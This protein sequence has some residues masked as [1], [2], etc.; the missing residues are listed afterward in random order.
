MREKLEDTGDGFYRLKNASGAEVRFVITG[1][2]SCIYKRGGKVRKVHNLIML[3]DIEAAERI[4]KRLEGIGNIHSDGRPILGLDSRDLLEITLEEC[5]RVLF[6]PAHIWTPHFSLFGANS[7]FDSIYECFDDLTSHI[8]ALETG[9]SSD[10]PMN[11]RLS[12]LDQFTLISN[13]DAHS[14][15]NLGREANL[16]ETEF[17]YQGIYD[18]LKGGQGFKGTIEFFPEEGKYHFDGHRNCHIR[19]SP[20]QTKAAGG[21]CP[22]CGRKVTVG[23]LHRVEELAD[24]NEGERPLEVKAFHSLV[25]LNE[26]LANA[27]GVGPKTKTVGREYFKLIGKFG[28][29]MS[30]LQE[31]PIEDI[32][33]PV[34]AEA[35]RRLR[36]GRINIEPGFDGEYG[37]IKLVNEEER[38]S[39]M[40]QMSMGSP[41]IIHHEPIEIKSMY[42]QG[43]KES[44]ATLD[45]DHSFS[46]NDQQ[47]NAVI[48]DGG[49]ILVIAGPGTGKTR[50]LIHRVLHL[51]E[52]KGV[53]HDLITGVTF[54]NRAALEMKARLQD[55]LGP[56]VGIQ[57]GTFHGI[58]LNILKE[59][60]GNDFIIIDEEDGVELLR[61]ILGERKDGISASRAVR[62]I[63]LLKSQVIL[64]GDERI[65]PDIE[66]I[67]RAYQEE[68]SYFKALDYDDIL[69]VTLQ[70]FEGDKVSGKIR[71]RFTH[72]L[73]DEFQD[74]NPLQYR[75]VRAFAQDGKNLFV[76]GDPDQAIYGFRGADHRFFQRLYG[77]F[78]K[79]K[80][81]NLSVNYRSTPQILG[82]A[83]V[84]IEQASQGFH[85][86]ALKP[87]RSSGS[88][89]RHIQLPTEL[90]EGIF[91]AHEIGRRVGGMDMLKARGREHIRSFSDIAV[92]FRTG[93]QIIQV[94][95]CLNKEGIPYR[96]VGRERVLN[97]KNIRHLLA[98]L[99]S[100]MDP[101]DDFHH[102]LALKTSPGVEESTVTLVKDLARSEKLSMRQAITVHIPRLARNLEECSRMAVKMAPSRLICEMSREGENGE[103]LDGLLRIAEGT[104]DIY[105]FLTQIS[106]SGESDLERA[107]R[108]KGGGEV[109]SLM[110]LHA[111]KGLEFPVVFIAGVEDGLVPLSND[112]EELRLFYVGMTRA[113]EE[114]ILLSSRRRTLFGKVQDMGESPYLKG[115]PQEYLCCEVEP[116]AGKV[117]RPQQL[118]LV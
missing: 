108:I 17:T 11:W 10:P 32:A 73:V 43:P 6:I 29:E 37:K 85:R 61:G 80:V 64:P 87:T 4:A 54:T 93:E 113:E 99:K 55:N 109:V 45:I 112:Q 22:V 47:R 51:I 3:P 82:A 40:G 77:D 19:W 90:S 28:S 102:L 57:V 115:I 75:L 13:S 86:Q 21:I 42:H 60:L 81:F 63:S 46:L 9:L 26:L 39:L 1:E 5:P 15:P 16:F 38:E 98:L 53:S 76:I 104:N 62:E 49:P 69:L 105:E 14:P 97:A 117:R 7:G 41:R 78:P 33:H 12:E 18:A 106:L 89:I 44:S 59:T 20:S 103:E 84:L 116:T 72:L 95:E 79:A 48:A 111:A 70:L 58:A 8:Y 30:V 114:L 2:I 88:R 96:V 56:K 94:E 25:P 110:T 31:A 92:L 71:S 50:T 66:P 118:S 34:V 91:I 36:A 67:Y 68:L 23:V 107:G 83:Q 101:E 52:E 35:I 100:A 24:R 74:V 65:A 27:L